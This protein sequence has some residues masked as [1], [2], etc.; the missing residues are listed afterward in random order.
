MCQPTRH[1]VHARM[2]ENIRQ[3]VLVAAAPRRFVRLPIQTATI[4]ECIS[5][6]N[7]SN[8]I[9]RTGRRLDPVP[10]HSPVAWRAP[11]QPADPAAAPPPFPA[12]TPPPLA[13]FPRMR[14]REENCNMVLLA[15][16][17]LFG[18][19]VAGGATLVE[20]RRHK[21]GAARR[22][23]D[24]LRRSSRRHAGQAN[25]LRQRPAAGARGRCAICP[26]HKSA[27]TLNLP[28]RTLAEPSS[29]N[30]PCARCRSRT[31]TVLSPRAQKRGSYP[32]LPPA[33][34]CFHK[35]RLME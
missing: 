32:P 17:T 9:C 7:T 6:Y 23:D 14:I 12:G 16:V 25:H 31:V 3:P 1:D 30:A 33:P 24:R 11:V 29:H 10:R 13:G 34:A 5:R 27:R 21:A 26:E 35:S 2:G 19:A 4:R 8:S 18:V 15:A 22:S 28:R 20:L